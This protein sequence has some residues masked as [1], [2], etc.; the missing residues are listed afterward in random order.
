MADIIATELQASQIGGGSPYTSNLMAT[1]VRAVA[2][3][4]NIRNSYANNQLVALKDLYKMGC[5]CNTECV[6]T[7]TACECTSYCSCTT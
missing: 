3:G 2:L 4:C 6:C 1:R 7:Y 5:V